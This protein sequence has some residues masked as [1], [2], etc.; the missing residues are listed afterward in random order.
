MKANMMILFVLLVASATPHQAIPVDRAWSILK[1]GAADKDPGTRSKAIRALGLLPTVRAAQGMAEKALTDT[2]K[3]V[4]VEAAGALGRMGAVSS[5]PKL[6]LALQDKEVKVVIASANALYQLKDPAAYEIYYTLLTGERKS[7]AGLI[8]SQLDILRNRKELEK[9]MF[10]TGIGF[11]PFGGMGYET[12]KTVT[13]DDTTPIRA[14]AAEKL[15][16]DPDTKSADALIEFS[17]DKKWQVRV[18]VVN[19]IAE[20][21]DPRLLDPVIVLLEDDNQSVRYDAAATVVLL[22]RFRARRPRK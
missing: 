18:A 7:S 8:Q 13:R 10:E 21:R 16:R 20:R 14:A 5:R 19:A 9:L 22:S 4:R 15:A 11:V 3:D 12:W 2:N 1:S 6:R 17:T